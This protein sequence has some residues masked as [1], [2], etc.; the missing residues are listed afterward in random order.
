MST[1]TLASRLAKLVP[2]G[3]SIDG[4]LSILQLIQEA[5]DELLDF[6]AEETWFIDPATG[7]PPFLR[8][9]AETLR[10][11]VNSDT[12][13]CPLVKSIAGVEFTL[14]A[15]RVSGV[16]VESR[17]GEGYGLSY[18]NRFS[19]PEEK[20]GLVLF[21]VPVSGSAATETDVAAVQFTKDPGTHTDR[22]RVLFT[23]EAPRLTSVNIPLVIPVEYEKAIIDYVL[24]TVSFYSNGREHERLERFENYW[25]KRYRDKSSASANQQPNE[26]IPR[27]C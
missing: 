17:M 22:Y 2:S 23:W 5:Q 12:L 4:S 21:K 6:E 26:T 15:K 3:W 18:D 20:Y 19:A 7:Y 11:T 1:R 10:Y 25:K 27:I 9:E 16:Y 13:S 8:S 24:G 14:R